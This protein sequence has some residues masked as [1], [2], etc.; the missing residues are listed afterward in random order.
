M[1]V[2]RY[3]NTKPF[4]TKEKNP[5]VKKFNGKVRIFI[6]GFKNILKSVRHAPTTKATHTGFKLIPSIKRVVPHTATE[7][8]IQ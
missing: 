6:I 3:Q 7:S 4:I 2:P 8:I 1:I 5:R